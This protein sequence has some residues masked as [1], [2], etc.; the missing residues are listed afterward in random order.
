MTSPDIEQS[1]LPEYRDNPFIAAL[2][3][4]WSTSETYERLRLLPHYDPA[5]RLYADHV[6]PHC[7]M[8]LFRYFEPL[9]QHLTLADRFGMLLRQGYLG[10]NPSQETISANCRIARPALKVATYQRSVS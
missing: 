5:E 8:R 7:I 6:R 1:V 4:L 9:E 10:R 3:P 2:P